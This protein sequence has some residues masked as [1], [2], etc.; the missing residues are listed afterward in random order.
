MDNSSTSVSPQ[1]LHQISGLIGEL[2]ITDALSVLSARFPGQV[3]FSTS[4]SFED[5]VI[6]HHILSADLPISI[7]TLD[8]GRL[9]AETYSVWSATNDRYNTRITAWYPDK[10]ELEP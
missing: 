5:Q 6:A 7:F 4:F 2:S 1:L 10:N 9:F 8:T 3:T